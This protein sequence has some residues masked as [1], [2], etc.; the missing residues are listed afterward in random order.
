MDSHQ[1]QQYL[2][3]FINHEIHLDQ[4]RSSAFKLERVQRLLKN[5]GDPQDHLKVI[6]VA[7]TKG[8]G[9]ICALT[10][11]ILKESN[12]RVGLYT[13][14]HINDMRERIRILA[15]APMNS[16][17]GDIFP[18]MI[19][20]RELADVLGE[21][22][23]LIEQSKIEEEIGRLS[24]FEVFTA[25][26]LY[27]FRQ[28]KVDFVV[29]ET[30]LGG[31]LDATNAAPSLIAVIAP[32]SLEHTHILGNTIS[33][34]TKEKAAII[35][36]RKQ[37]VIISPQDDQAKEILKNRCSQFDID[38]VWT[39]EQAK[40]TLISQSVNGQVIDIST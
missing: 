11:N 1:T 5:L 22:K 40:S 3:S 2:E 34:I 27:Y 4:A 25:L 13:S 20:N 35:K 8:K 10:A 28:Q 7:G 23:P 39:S 18:D 21:I 26:A 37:N 15:K 36:E 9:S 30:G 19:S 6:H 29:L 31:R 16:N 17:S 24:F 33:D 14:P 38:P 12:Y 32:I